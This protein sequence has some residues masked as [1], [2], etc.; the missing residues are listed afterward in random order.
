VSVAPAVSGG[1]RSPQVKLRPI[2]VAVGVAFLVLLGLRIVA[3]PMRVSSDSM[4]PAYSKGDEILVQKFGA[5]VGEPARG[6][7]VVIRS[8]VSGDLA[9]KR[10]A[11]LG[12]QTVGIADGVLRVDGHEVPEPYIDRAEVRGTYFGPIRVPAG[13]VFLLGDQRFGSVD[14]RSFGPVPVDSMVG[15]VMLRVWP[16]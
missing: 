6:D 9:I 16:P 3:E 13:T 15:R 4:K 5:H 1:P 11:A 2:L 12:G 14:S 10:V 7:I 8:P